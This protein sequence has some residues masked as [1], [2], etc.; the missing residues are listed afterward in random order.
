MHE[1]RLNDIKAEC[2]ITKAEVYIYMARQC[3]NAFLFL[4][5]YWQMCVNRE[6]CMCIL[7]FRDKFTSAICIFI[8][9]LAMTE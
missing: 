3:N 2:T 5:I 1:A 9:I 6:M 4:K 7:I 8:V